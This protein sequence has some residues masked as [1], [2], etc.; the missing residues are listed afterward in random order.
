[1]NFK[2]LMENDKYL[3]LPGVYDCLSAKMAQEAGFEALFLSGGALSVAGY[4]K[5][6]IGFL[7]TADYV[8]MAEK[9][10]DVTGLPLLVDADNGFGNAIHVADLARQYVRVGAKGLQ[11]D[12]Q[13]VPQS[14]PS[15]HKEANCWELVEPKLKAIRDAV[16]DDFLL[17]FRTVTNFTDNVDEAIKRINRA[18]ELGA[19][20]AYIDGIKSEEELRKIAEEAEIPL[21][22]NMNE[23]GVAANLPIDEVK[24]LGYRIGLYPVSAMAVAANAMHDL[25]VDL[26]ATATT[27]KH[28]DHMYNPVKVYNSMGL[29]S[30]TDKYLPLYEHENE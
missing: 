27:L 19:D 9:I 17:L 22:I 25:F 16:P 6:D 18:Y 28:R 5:P 21:M 30:L 15:T 7:H 10:I 2:T 24:E 12:D 26:K 3:I 8:R 1:M 29:Q 11:I 4:G 20:V 23:K 13:I 14:V